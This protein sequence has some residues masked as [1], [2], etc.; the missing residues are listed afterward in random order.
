VFRRALQIIPPAYQSSCWR[1]KE[2][3]AI[4]LSDTG[5]VQQRELSAA[6]K[7][8]ARGLK[9][10]FILSYCYHLSLRDL[11]ENV[12]EEAFVAF[13]GLDRCFNR[14]YGWSRLGGELYHLAPASAYFQK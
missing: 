14:S 1:W 9:Y 5:M 8:N 3:F 6:Q 12:T 13:S 10:P 4:V 2:P 7:R 11:L